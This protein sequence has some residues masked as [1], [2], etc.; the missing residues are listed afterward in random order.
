LRRTLSFQNLICACAFLLAT[1]ALAQTP[2]GGAPS[3]QSP[4]NMPSQRPDLNGPADPSANSMPARVDDKKFVKDAALG[5][6]TEVEL[7]KLALQKAS[8]ND[9]KQFAQKMVDDHTKANDQLKQV[10][11]RDNMEI[12]GSLDPKHQSRID[13]LSKLSGQEFDKAYVKDQLKDH[14]SDVAEFN[15][16]A[17][18]GSDPNV[19]AFASSTLPTVQQHLELVKNLHKS[20]KEAAK[21]AKVSS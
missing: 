7:G 2:G 14:E 8:S 6:M 20:E 18:S 16:E 12:H 10:A 17:Q 15:A 3:S 19:K 4:S 11:T 21:Q 13:K 9:V 5:G 1:G